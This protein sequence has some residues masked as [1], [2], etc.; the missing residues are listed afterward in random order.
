MQE[1]VTGAAMEPMTTL[2]AGFFFVEH[3]NVPTA[4]GVKPGGRRRA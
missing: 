3:K 2:D 4:I 1:A